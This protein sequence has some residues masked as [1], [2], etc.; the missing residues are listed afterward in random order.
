MARKGIDIND[1]KKIPEK[2]A[3]IPMAHKVVALAALL[4]VSGVVYYFFFFSEVQQN[5]AN[6][7]KRI[8]KLKSDLVKLDEYQ[9]DERTQER[10]KERKNELLKRLEEQLPKSTNP[11]EFQEEIYKRAKLAGVRVASVTQ[12]D[13]LIEGQFKAVPFT[14]DLSGTFVQLGQFFNHI[15]RMTRL[16]RLSNVNLTVAERKADHHIISAKVIA[17]AFQALTDADKAGAPAA[18]APTPPPKK[19]GKKPAK[20]G[21]GKKKKGGDD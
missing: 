2:F 19:G 5:R 9:K 7:E 17:S 14:L 6:V 12:A 10:E 8:T 21:H 20:G 11:I 13:P 18:A 4:V 15:S 3:K 16:V 1:L